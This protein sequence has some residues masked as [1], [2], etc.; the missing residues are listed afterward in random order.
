MRSRSPK[1]DHF[2]SEGDSNISPHRAAWSAEHLDAQARHWL[3]EDAKYFL[4]QSLSTPCLNVLKGCNAASIEDVQGR[5]LLD[6]H[7]NNVHQVGF[8]H[9][10]V[11]EAIIAQ[12]R[13]LCFCTRRYTNVAAITL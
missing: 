12:M 5:Q 8:S 7:G 6:F 2:K 11:V 13:E 3:E 1:L 4:H 9:P 10:R